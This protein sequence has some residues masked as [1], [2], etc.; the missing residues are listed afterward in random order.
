MSVGARLRA[1]RRD[2]LGRPVWDVER[3]VLPTADLH[4]A[5]AIARLVLIVH[6]VVPAGWVAVGVK[7]HR[8]VAVIKAHVPQ[9]ILDK[10]IIV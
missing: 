3:A 9:I 4:I 10:K 1:D 8:L 6:Y 2:H 5:V 7:L